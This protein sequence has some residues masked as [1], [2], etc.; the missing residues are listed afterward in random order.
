MRSALAH[1]QCHWAA[2][3]SEAAAVTVT[4]PGG[5]ARPD[6]PAGRPATG[7]RA[8]TGATTPTAAPVKGSTKLIIN[9]IW[10]AIITCRSGRQR[11]GASGVRT[12]GG[13]MTKLGNCPCCCLLRSAAGIGI[14]MCCLMQVTVALAAPSLEPPPCSCLPGRA[15]I[16]TVSAGRQPPAATCTHGRLT[17]REFAASHNDYGARGDVQRAHAD[18]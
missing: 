4:S 8:R 10:P 16:A 6:P 17:S 2:V 13:L 3:L 18:R 12:K 14:K 1:A 9:Q 15:R 5:R 7:T 11:G